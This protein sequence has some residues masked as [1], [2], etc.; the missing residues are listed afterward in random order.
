MALAARRLVWTG[1]AALFIGGCGGGGSAPQPEPAPPPVIVSLAALSPNTVREEENPTVDVTVEVGSTAHAG[2]TVA[3]EYSGTAERDRDYTAGADSVEI[4][5][6]AD[7]AS[8]ALDV[9]RDFDAEGDETI[10]VSLGTI[11]GNAQAGADSS[12]TL[13]IADGPAA[14]VHKTAVEPSAEP[15]SVLPV[16][17]RITETAVEIA[18]AVII[19]EG[20]EDAPTQVL[21]EFS[22]DANFETDINPFGRV[23]L[24]GAPADATSFTEHDFLLP[25]SRLVANGSYHVRVHFGDRMGD[26]DEEFSP[27]TTFQ[28]SFATNAEGL[29]ATRCRAPASS[30]GAGPDPLF[31]EQWHLA[32]TGQTAFSGTAGV[33][34][35]DLQMNQA[36]DNSRNGRG[37]RLAVVDSGLEICHPDLAANV[38]PGRSYNFGHA[39][40]A[41]A[42]ATDPFN[43]DLFGDHGT[44]V[45][46]V[47]A[48]AANNGAG[49]RGVAPEVFLRGFNP[50]G[51]LGD[52]FDVELLQSLGGS[53]RNPD[54]A[55]AD[56]FNMSFGI[57]IP[58]RNSDPDFARL[59]RMGTTDLRGGRG[60]LY[61]KAAGNEFGLCA[62][63]PLNEEIGCLGSNG[64]PDNNLPW[65]LVVGGFNANDVRS[66]YSSAGAN[67]WIVAPSGEDGIDAPAIITTDQQGSERG[68]S[69]EYDP[70][71]LPLAPGHVLNPNGDYIS[72]FGGTSSAAPAA[73][74]AIAV[75]L[76]IYPELTW[77]DVKH[78]LASTARRIDPDRAQVRAAFNGAPYVAQPAWQTNAAGYDFHNW[79]GFG[80]LALDEA[81]AFAADHA[82]NSLGAFTESG[83][84]PSGEPQELD[85]AIPDKD[86]Q[87]V[88]HTLSVAGLP[89]AASIEAVIVELDIEHRY[90]AD[91]GVAVTSPGGTRS[92]VNAPFNALLEDFPG[93]SDWQLLS[94]A[95]YGE[96]PNGEWTIQVVDLAAGDTGVLQS[97]RLRFHYG[98]HPDSS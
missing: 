12:V 76:G 61:V 16:S 9:F 46:G 8:V 75:L 27:L 74:G 58:S 62:P 43:M 23:D 5:A 38:E 54:S 18:V 78:I 98:E 24:S 66:S 25:L 63:H 53:D 6:G 80:A 57:E 65:L 29:V 79:Y 96:T 15:A 21:A 35:A 39:L 69:M 49:G 88:T 60:A 20:L 11:T 50:G 68:Y 81:V 71:E 67:L 1:A 82:P 17:F 13:T 45:A 31:A 47:A 48:A 32:N 44:S 3:L 14:E 51:S 33:A 95:F 86:G 77:R 93:M 41:G 87:G 36:I 90:G 28:F 83:W 26:A 92:V 19:P 55:S 94:N 59:F 52:R 2:L 40:R 64:D 10:T 7:R 4:A 85:L 42:L 37:V 22:S 91:L 72:I 70:E 89:D 34:G 97:W 56:I 73:A 30:S 84:F